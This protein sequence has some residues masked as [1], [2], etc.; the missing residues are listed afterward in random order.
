MAS[1]M[2]LLSFFSDPNSSVYLELAQV[3]AMM[4]FQPF[5]AVGNPSMTSINTSEFGNLYLRVVVSPFNGSFRRLAR[6]QISQVSVNIFIC[7][8]MS[9]HHITSWI[10]LNMIW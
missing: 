9:G 2:A 3:I 1:A 5:R 7:L 4:Y 10:L 6:W 8:V